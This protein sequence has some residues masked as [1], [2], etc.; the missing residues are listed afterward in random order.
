MRFGIE[1]SGVP[2]LASSKLGQ[3]GQEVG[4]DLQ[5]AFLAVERKQAENGQNKADAVGD[6]GALNHLPRE[7]TICHHP[8]QVTVI[9][10]TYIQKGQNYVNERSYADDM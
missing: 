8:S 3:N 9:L 1:S 4:E 7:K 10:F 5:A 2:M 6:H